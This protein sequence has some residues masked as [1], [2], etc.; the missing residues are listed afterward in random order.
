MT[1]SFLTKLITVLAF[2]LFLL[3]AIFTIFTSIV[4]GNITKDYSNILNYSVESA[5]GGIITEINQ[6][7]SYI[8][9]LDQ[10]NIAIPSGYYA[11]GYAESGAAQL[12]ISGIDGPQPY[13]LKL[14]NLD[15]YVDKST[16]LPLNS[17]F[18]NTTEND[19]YLFTVKQSD[20]KHLFILKKMDDIL[21]NMSLFNFS[22]IVIMS[23][24]GATLYSYTSDNYSSIIS[25]SSSD[26]VQSFTSGETFTTNSSISGE[27][28]IISVAHKL[29]DYDIRVLAYMPYDNFSAY[30]NNY[31]KYHLMQALTI[32]FI[33]IASAVLVTEIIRRRN[34][35]PT[36][37]TSGNNLILTIK[38]N[39]DIIYKS[40]LFKK[41]FDV[42]NIIKY[43]KNEST[44]DLD[45]IF[46]SNEALYV[47]LTDKEGNIN[48]F[49][50][51]ILW[52]I[53]GYKL[54]GN[55]CTK[56]LAEYRKLKT[57]DIIDGVTKLAYQKSFEEDFDKMVVKGRGIRGLF[58]QISAINLASF[59]L[60]LGEHLSETL[61]R[62]FAE[63]VSSVFSMY[64]KLYIMS[65]QDILF[66]CDDLNSAS[67]IV[68]NIASITDP[69]GKPIRVRENVIKLDIKVGLLSLDTVGQNI[70]V[71]NI[72]CNTFIALKNATDSIRS[73]YYILRSANFSRMRTNFA[74]DGTVEK[75]LAN[76]ELDVYFQPQYS[77]KEK[78]IVGYE[79]LTRIIGER[80]RE[81]STGDFISI[82]EKYGGMLEL[83]K[84]VYI[85]SMQFATKVQ[86]KNIAISVNVSPLQLMQMGFVESFL[87]AYRS[88][89]L[90][91]HSI[92]VE[93]TETTM[94]YSF[95]EVV[96]KLNILRQHGIETHIDDF[97]VA[98]SSM[99]Y[100][101]TLPIQALKIDK[102]LIDDID[103]S[104][105]RLAIVR[106]IINLAKDL[107]LECVAEGVET[108]AQK[109]KLESVKCDR[110]QGYLIG[111]A[112]PEKDAIELLKKD[113][114]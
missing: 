48:S 38:R 27:A 74:A 57:A 51:T 99:L 53:Y 12:H 4:K 110:I 111:K 47:D 32:M 92:V 50:F 97:G 54:I 21:D 66:F 33:C 69:L 100:L 96:S 58:A 31:M 90:K 26:V 59:K 103:K 83:G 45:T 104:K 39:G 18:S 34:S 87:E 20:N 6:A 42:D 60:M 35:I 82:A 25:N 10:D 3:V 95:E 105:E 9:L 80:S 71:D 30:I 52:S 36:F 106:N 23:T 40:K 63:L 89:N 113:F 67:E 24:D 61:M 46:R 86:N 109:K 75:M 112:V 44:Q 16:I 94:I 29:D 7:Q 84:Y 2:V 62:S 8:D 49:H 79:A 14:S 19:R 43:I 15:I 28:M 114:Y 64:G 91:P 11:A 88:H 68:N 70:N 107:K 22:N 102:S 98:Y 55:E 72:L 101:Q 37:S 85:K 65:S 77:L 13:T 56:E 108:E 5:Q 93:I 76:N 1:K 41:D 17:L 78:R 73:K 81:I